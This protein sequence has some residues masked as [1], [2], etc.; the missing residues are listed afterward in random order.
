[1]LGLA[2]T[3]I[4]RY[5]FHLPNLEIETRTLSGGQQK[6]VAIGRALL[7]EPRLLLL[8]EPTAALGVTERN[9]VLNVI[10]ELRANGVGVILCT[11]SPEEISATAERLLVLRHGKLI[12]DGSVAALD[13][14]GLAELMSS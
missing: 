1:M 2:R 9:V 3:L 13:R 4:A 11:H 12:H 5:R 6:A 14:V 7:S 8:D 10:R